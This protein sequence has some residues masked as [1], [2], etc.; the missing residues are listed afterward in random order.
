MQRALV[1]SR[2]KN[3]IWEE[4]QKKASQLSDCRVNLVAVKEWVELRDNE[5]ESMDPLGNDLDTLARQKEE[6]RVSQ[7]EYDY[8]FVF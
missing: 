3:R 1:F 8:G 6:I 7:G 2:L 4:E 5:L